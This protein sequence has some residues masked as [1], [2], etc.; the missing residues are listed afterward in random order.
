MLW[1]LK[2]SLVVVDQNC[3]SMTSQEGKSE[4]SRNGALGVS[5][6]AIGLERFKKLLLASLVCSM[7]CNSPAHAVDDQSFTERALSSGG[8]KA[9]SWRPSPILFGRAGACKPNLAEMDQEAFRRAS[10]RVGAALAGVI[11][12]SFEANDLFSVRYSEI[13]VRF[14]IYANGKFYGAASDEA[15]TLVSASV[16]RDS[17]LVFRQ[18]AGSVQLNIFRQNKHVAIEIEAE[19]NLSLEGVA[20]ADHQ[21]M[22]I[23]RSASGSS[24]TLVSVAYSQAT[25]PQILVWRRPVSTGQYIQLKES[26]LTEFVGPCHQRS[27]LNFPTNLRCNLV[28][29]AA[30]STAFF[31]GRITDPPARIVYVQGG[32]YTPSMPLARFA[33]VVSMAASSQAHITAPATLFPQIALSSDQISGQS[34]ANDVATSNKQVRDAVDFAAANGERVVLIA[35]SLGAQLIEDSVN[36]SHP[37]DIILFSGAIQPIGLIDKPFQRSSSENGEVLPA[38]KHQLEI[39]EAIEIE[40]RIQRNRPSQYR[41]KQYRDWMDTKGVQTIKMICGRKPQT[42]LVIIRSQHDPIS[43]INREELQ[44]QISDCSRRGFKVETLDLPG[45]S[46]ASPE[47]AKSAALISKLLQEFFV[48]EV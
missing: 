19:S 33:N 31:V 5:H 41:L 23:F 34:F 11:A 7:V 22:L 18:K 47:L 27:D 35:E 17:L 37:L 44:R 10:S 12:R 26:G 48:G 14:C 25:D 13:G 36:S 28:Q 30:K 1:G 4:T 9:L 32:P 29:T 43:Q 8:W 42:R 16:F 15:R 6:S 2:L 46:H 40:N 20:E 45:A 21:Q 39:Q 3:F 38:Q 24:Y